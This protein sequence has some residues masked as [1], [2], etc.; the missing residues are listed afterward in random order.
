MSLVKFFVVFFI[1]VYAV[2]TLGMY[3][4]QRK[5]QY[6]P[7][8]KG[9]TPESVGI[10]GASVETL[11]TADGEK[12]ILWYAPAMA[13]LPTILYFQGNAG[14]IGD[15][16]L[17]FNYYQSR[18]FGVAYLSYR[19]FGG[20]SG[21]PS[22][23]GLMADADAAYDW[24]IA[25]AVEPNKIALLGESLGSGVAVQLAAK[26]EVGAVA[27]EAP[28]TST[29]EVAAKIYWW[30]PVHALMKDQ[31]KSIDFIAAVVAPLLIIHGE[32][33]RLIPV[34]Y[35]RRLFAAANQPKELEIVPGFGH[36][37]LFEEATW[38]REAEFFARVVK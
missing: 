28:Y 12:I 6:H 37:V 21:S 18:G 27:L 20:S 25:K 1:V 26:R 30:L 29:V 5:L 23:A 7:A 4:F 15:R 24:L 22:E 31:F 33:D 34:E 38:A 35:G 32:E 17:R 14:E 19:G 13:G 16:P 36:D 8:N 9:L 2:A 3:V 10:I 11:T